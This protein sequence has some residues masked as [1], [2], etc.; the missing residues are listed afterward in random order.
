MAVP[1]I[2]I[3]PPLDN[4]NLAKGY[5]YDNL[6]DQKNSESLFVILTF[7]GDGTRA[8]ALSYGVLEKLRN[9][10]IWLIIKQNLI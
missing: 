5:R 4:Y 6:S 7:S 2:S 9:T 1:V 8:A 3:T 10:P